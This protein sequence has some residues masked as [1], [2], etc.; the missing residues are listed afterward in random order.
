MKTEL[1]ES[2]FQTGEIW[3]RWLFLVDENYFENGAFRE[4]QGHDNHV[5]SRVFLKHKSK[6]AG[7]C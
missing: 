3:K 2:A 4:L 6:T 1:F 7:D 5:V